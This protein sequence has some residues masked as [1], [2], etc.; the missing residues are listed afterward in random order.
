MEKAKSESASDRSLVLERVFDAPRA[1]VFEAWTKP[2]HLVRWSCPEGMTIPECR[3]DFRVGGEFYTL[4]VKPDGEKFPLSGVYKEIVPDQL[5][6]MT[7]G[8]IEDDGT[9][10]WETILTLRFSDEG[11]K[12]KVRLEQSVFKSVESRDGHRFGWSSCF[13]QLGKYLENHKVEAKS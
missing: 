10:P 3:G 1:L 8:W 7:H 12:T 6:V 5:L 9:R 11:G 13:D 4:M 2:E